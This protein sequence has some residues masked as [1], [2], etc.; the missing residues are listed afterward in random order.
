MDFLLWDVGNFTFYTGYMHSPQRCFERTV[1]LLLLK[2]CLLLGPSRGMTLMLCYCVKDESWVWENVPG[3][4]K[5]Q[6]PGKDIWN[7][8]L[9]TIIGPE[10]KRMTKI[11]DWNY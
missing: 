8:Y 6:K 10:K 11:F 4:N 5:L 2:L 1:T 9:Y 7:I 3:E